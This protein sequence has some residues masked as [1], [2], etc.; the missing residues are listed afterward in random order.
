MDPAQQQ[1]PQLAPQGQGQP[2]AQHPQGQGP[3]SGP[4]QRHPKCPR[5]RP[6]PPPAGH[7][8]VHLQGD[9]ETDLE[10]LFNVVMSQ[11][12]QHA[13]DGAHEV[14]E[15]PIFFFVTKSDMQRGRETERK[16]FHPMIHS[17]GSCNGWS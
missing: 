16:I 8:I 7:Q 3:L 5:W 17:P 13:P 1:L 14:L 9:S 11:D 2:P 15:A 6:R 12:S 4:G 10:A